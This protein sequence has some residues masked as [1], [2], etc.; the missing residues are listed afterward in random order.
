M[1][2]EEHSAILSTF[3]KL[4]FVIKTFVL[5][6]FECKTVLYCTVNFPEGFN[7]AKIKSSQN[8]TI[9]LSFTD[10]GKSCSSCEF[11]TSQTCLLNPI[12]RIKFL[13]KFPNLQY[14]AFF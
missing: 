13:R 2:Q 3:I 14:F 6:N 5:S 8:G 4:P 9:I 7:L 12:S 10:G 11:L 1:L